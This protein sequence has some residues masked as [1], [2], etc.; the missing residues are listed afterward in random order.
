MEEQYV[1][2]V[3]FGTLNGRAVVVRVSDGEVLASAAADYEHGVMDESLTAGDGQKLPP[4]FALQVPN[5]YLAVFREAVPEAL[6]SSGIDASAVIGPGLDVTSATVVAAKKDGT[7]L[8]ELEKFRNRP[9]AY[10]KLWKHHGAHEQSERMVELAEERN[11]KWLGRYGGIISSELLV[12]KVLETLERDPEV[13]AAADVYADALDWLVWRLTGE[14][15]YA[16]RRSHQERLPDADVRRCPQHARLR[17]HHRTGWR[18]RV[19]DL[20]GSRRRGIQEHSRRIGSH[21]SQEHGRLQTGPRE[22]ESL[23]RPLRGIPSA[24]RPLRPG[25]E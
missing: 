2:G 14:L 25:Y 7:P 3:D 12:P 17:G 18:P 4:D 1:V 24:A 13:F 10:V 5:D 20:R 23:R 8:C 22:R 16:A 19:R 21:G 6:Q 15:V 11:E 9:H